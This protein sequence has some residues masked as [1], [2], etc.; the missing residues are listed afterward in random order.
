MLRVYS[1]HNDIIVVSGSRLG[2][3]A[4]LLVLVAAAVALALGAHLRL[5]A[6]QDDAFVVSRSGS[7]RRSRQGS[8]GCDSGT[9]RKAS[10]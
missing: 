4:R 5:L 7:S 10:D 3:F 9:G 1:Q 2:L 8:T 6:V